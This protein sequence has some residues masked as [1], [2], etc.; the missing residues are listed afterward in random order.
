MLNNMR[1][2]KS[3]IYLFNIVP[4]YRPKLSDIYD[5]ARTQSYKK[6]AWNAACLPSFGQR[7]KQNAFFLD[8]EDICGDGLSSL[9]LLYVFAC[10][11]DKE[12]ALINWVSPGDFTITE[13]NSPIFTANEGFQANSGYLQT[14]FTPSTHGV[15]YTLDECGV[16][17][18]IFNEFS[19]TVNFAFGCRGSGG[20]NTD[21]FL[22]PKTGGSPNHTF[23]LQGGLSN[24]GT[25][26]T[27]VGFYHLRR[28]ADDD[29]RLF[30][31]GAQVGNVVTNASSS[32]PDVEL[33]IL[34]FNSNGTPNIGTIKM[35][36][37]GLGASL[38]GSES[39]LY[40][41]WN[42]YFTSL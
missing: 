41:A 14:G 40:T 20:T 34:A 2:T 32:L 18:N 17:C 28:V 31:N 38:S 30:K 26:V 33:Y 22:S 1:R 35:S 3:G 4:R 5:Y 7:V 16:F 29:S 10:D 25:G 15:N 19:A 23:S 12:F 24:V 36:V 8:L 11:A 21:I 37:F 42:D 39:A 6:E 9:D 13:V 27:A